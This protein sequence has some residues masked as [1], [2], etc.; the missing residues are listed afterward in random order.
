M[1]KKD[2]KEGALKSI[3]AVKEGTAALFEKLENER[4]I[5]RKFVLGGPSL[6]A[7]V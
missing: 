3:S 7:T 6:R 2:D 5:K 4:N 1:K